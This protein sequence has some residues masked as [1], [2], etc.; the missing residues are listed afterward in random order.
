MTKRIIFGFY[1]FLSGLLPY[2]WLIDLHC[3]IIKNECMTKRKAKNPIR[4][5]VRANCREAMGSMM[6][7]QIVSQSE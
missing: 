7:I 3:C 4:K 6:H 1:A 5:Y 2:L